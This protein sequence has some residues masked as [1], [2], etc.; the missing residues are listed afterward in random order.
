VQLELSKSSFKFAFADDSL[1]LEVAET[2]RVTNSGNA[3][4]KFKWT[5]SE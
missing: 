2:L 5:M 3:T 1:N 4:A